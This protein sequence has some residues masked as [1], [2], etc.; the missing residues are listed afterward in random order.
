MLYCKTGL[1]KSF[2]FNKELYSSIS[3]NL[4]FSRKK[5]EGWW[6]SKEIPVKILVAIRTGETNKVVSDYNK[7]R[8]FEADIEEDWEKYKSLYDIGL[9][10]SKQIFEKIVKNADD[11]YM[12]SLAYPVGAVYCIDH[13]EVVFHVVI[14]DLVNIDLADGYY[15]M[16]ISNVLFSGEPNTPLIKSLI[17]VGEKQSFRKVD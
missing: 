3:G 11:I 13:Y 7:N 1:A 17:I 15:L 10:A 16:P 2:E 6:N 5:S 8:F 9:L 4:F 14:D 12:H